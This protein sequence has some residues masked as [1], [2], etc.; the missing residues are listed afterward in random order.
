MIA[1]KGADHIRGVPLLAPLTMHATG[2]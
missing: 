2:A 1:E